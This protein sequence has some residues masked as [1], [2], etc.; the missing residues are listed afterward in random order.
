MIRWVHN[1]SRSVFIRLMLIILT[2]GF[3][4]NLVVV[5]SFGRFQHRSAETYHRIAAHYVQT[6]LAAIGDPPSRQRAEEISSATGFV[7][8]YRNS[9]LVWQTPHTGEA[10]PEPAR[11][12]MRQVSPRT[13]VGFFRGNTLIRH[14]LSEGE[15]S[16]IV[17][18]SESAERGLRLWMLFVLTALSFILGVAYLLIRRILKPLHRMKS[19]MEALHAGRLDYRI[20][21]HGAVEFREL[22]DTFN[23]MTI[24]VRDMLQSKERLLLDVSHEL[25]S[26]IARMKIALA[27]MPEDAQ[28]RS[29]HEDLR[30]MEAMV[31]TILASARLQH[32]AD[33]L[34]KTSVSLSWLVAEAI[35]PL[36]DRAP[37][38]LIAPS[39]DILIR[40]DKDKI[41]TA[42][43]NIV[44]NAIKYSNAQSAPVTVS[45][46]ADTTRV[47]LTVEDNGIGIP[48][49]DLPRIF[50]PF[51]RVDD[52]RSRLSGGFGL[53]LSLAKTIVEAHGGTIHASSASDGTR[54]AIVLRR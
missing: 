21:Q 11:Y 24:R 48:A 53:G 51:F 43:Q 54:V 45:W 5:L 46:E 13:V 8:S 10:L 28:T 40:L 14:S 37:G 47:T 19:A 39:A 32:T 23:T 17:P 16:F 27:M 41:R 26:P 6:L 3:L 31:T 12:R 25:R 36:Q 22:A 30:E 44:E 34:K 52:S 20:P 7:I 18:R 35:E 1:L 2:A 33:T 9:G 49:G 42:I 29:L 50:E 4:I 15:L 38:V